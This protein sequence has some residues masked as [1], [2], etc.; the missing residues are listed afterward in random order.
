MNNFLKS[1]LNDYIKCIKREGLDLLSREEEIQLA[2]KAKKGDMASKNKLFFANVRLVILIAKKFLKKDV[3]LVDLIQEGNIGL[4][5]AIDKFDYRKRYKFSTYAFW[6]IRHYIQK[7]LYNCCRDVPI[8]V[9][10]EEFLRKVERKLA[11]LERANYS[12][13]TSH[14][15]AEALNESQ[16][17][18]DMI[19]NLAQP[20]VSLDKEVG[21]DGSQSF[22]E[23][24]VSDEK[25]ETESVVMNKMMKNAIKK[26]LSSLL[27]IERKVI[28]YRFGF[29]DGVRYTLKETSDMFNSSPETIRRIEVSV[30]EKIKKN[31]D[32]LRDFIDS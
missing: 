14:E 30:L 23:I 17:K 13:V 8:P 3:N 12:S 29:H 6:W 5:K 26:I 4:L 9:K 32:Y 11:E 7:Y 27:D 24:A 2:K 1:E 25:W 31:N 15:I 22:H 28:M 21:P 16:T 19:L 18:V 10:K 20:S